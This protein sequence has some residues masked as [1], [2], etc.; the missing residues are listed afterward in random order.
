MASAEY[1]R[2]KAAEF[3]A[4][5]KQEPDPTRRANLDW[6]ALSYMRLAEHADLNEKTDIVY[7]TPP[8]AA[9]HEPTPQQQQVQ[10]QQSKSSKSD[11]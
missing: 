1:Y 5:A 8:M 11:E 6:L 7:E 3:G 10:Q 2:T 4:K 9:Q